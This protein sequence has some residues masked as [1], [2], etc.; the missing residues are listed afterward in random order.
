MP[1]QT[2]REPVPRSSPHPCLCACCTGA[3]CLVGRQRGCHRRRKS[4]TDHAPEQAHCSPATVQHQASWAH[5]RYQVGEDGHPD[6][7]RGPQSKQATTTL[8]L[9]GYSTRQCGRGAAPCRAD[10]GDLTCHPYQII[11]VLDGLMDCAKNK[12]QLL[13]GW[14]VG[15][16]PD[17][18]VQLCFVNCRN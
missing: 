8:G 4:W 1:P 6:K 3:R 14:L 17:G 7:C 2:S 10:K 5:M 15:V 16:R 13:V 12:E 18:A 11:V 9:Q